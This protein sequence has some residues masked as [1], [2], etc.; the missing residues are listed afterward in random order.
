MVVSTKSKE[1]FDCLDDI[2]SNKELI[3]YSDVL[4]VKFIC[5]N[6]EQSDKVQT[7]IDQNENIKSEKLMKD[8]LHKLYNEYVI[9]DNE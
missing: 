7:I 1:K 9:E 8:E 5:L 4:P 6:T 2:L 3:L